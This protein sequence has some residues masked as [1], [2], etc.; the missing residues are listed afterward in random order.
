[1]LKRIITAIVCIAILIP[2]LIFSDTWIFTLVL[3][4]LALLAV[5]EI[6][7]CINVRR[8]YLLAITSYIFTAVVIF[9]MTTFYMEFDNFIPTLFAGRIGIGDLLYYY[10]ISQHY[11]A[12]QMA[13]N[14]AI[15]IFTHFYRSM[16]DRYRRILCG[17]SS[18]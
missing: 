2:V 6:T 5:Y 10:W 15:F 16:D 1:M 3:G 9:L 14:R 4:L 17:G 18:W 8:K 12:S 11:F 13:G 7:G